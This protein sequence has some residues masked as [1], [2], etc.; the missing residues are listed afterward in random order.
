LFTLLLRTLQV[1]TARFNMLSDGD[2]IAVL[3]M[4]NGVTRRHPIDKQSWILW[5]L[6]RQ[7]QFNRV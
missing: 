5:L 7:C 6:Y 3:H 2:A 1:F 4:H